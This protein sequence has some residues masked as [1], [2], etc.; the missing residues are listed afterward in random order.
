MDLLTYITRDGR[1]VALHSDADCAAAIRSGD[2]HANSIV[3]D[4]VSGRWMR[5]SEHTFLGD[6]L[7]RVQPEPQAPAPSRSHRGA[8]VV[9]WLVAVAAPALIAFARGADGVYVLMRSLLCTA[10][11][12]T[13]GAIMLHFVRSEKGRLR[14]SVALAALTLAAGATALAGQP[15]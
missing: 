12:G 1:E 4:G 9:V 7:A 8:M 13:V 11:L 3:M 2:L 10:L 6:L 15:L 5:A 14:V